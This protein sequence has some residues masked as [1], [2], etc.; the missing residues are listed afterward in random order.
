MQVDCSFKLRILDGAEFMLSNAVKRE[1]HSGSFDGPVIIE[2]FA[3]SGI[4]FGRG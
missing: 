3:N 4:L 1:E 2:L